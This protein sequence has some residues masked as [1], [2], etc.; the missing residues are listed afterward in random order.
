MRC[1]AGFRPPYTCRAAQSLVAIALRIAALSPAASSWAIVTDAGGVEARRSST[2]P[3]AARR[4]GARPT[5]TT[6]T[7]R[8]AAARA[9]HS[10]AC[11]E[12]HVR[13]A[14]SVSSLAWTN[15]NVARSP[16]SAIGSLWGKY[17]YCAP[18]APW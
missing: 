10:A 4:P 17:R 9:R 12:P 8:P 11:C 16:S 7:P 3:A 14:L 18:T 13:T 1:N 15:T 2:R 5:A 6:S